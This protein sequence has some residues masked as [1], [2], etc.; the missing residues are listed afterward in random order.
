MGIHLHRL[1]WSWIDPAGSHHELITV[2]EPPPLRGAL[3]IVNLKATLA[4]NGPG[5][6]LR[7][8][9]ARTSLGMWH[10]HMPGVVPPFT[11]HHL[12]PLSM[13]C[14][15]D[16]AE[17]CKFLASICPSGSWWALLSTWESGEAVGS[18]V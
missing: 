5:D 18:F 13:L 16:E 7:P 17:M 3:R 2:G 10:G 15:T 11:E 9:C 8:G 4:Q 14:A 12:H 1:Q 6:A